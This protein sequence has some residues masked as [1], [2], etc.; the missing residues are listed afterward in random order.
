LEARISFIDH[1]ESK[2]SWINAKAIAEEIE[3]YDRWLYGTIR[4]L[5]I[6]SEIRDIDGDAVAAYPP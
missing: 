3:I 4:N 5:G 6:Q 2:S 1:D